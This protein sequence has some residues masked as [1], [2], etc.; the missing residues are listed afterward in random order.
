MK[1]ICLVLVLMAIAAGVY[2]VLRKKKSPIRSEAESSEDNKPGADGEND[3][4]AAIEAAARLDFLAHIRSFAG[5]VGPL[6]QAVSDGST[7]AITLM[8][9]AWEHQVQDYANLSRYFQLIVKAPEA[10]DVLG[11]ADTWISTL[12]KWG[13]AHDN[14]GEIIT[15][16]SQTAKRYL[17]DQSCGFGSKVKIQRP[18]WYITLDGETQVVEQGTGLLQKQE[19]ESLCRRKLETEQ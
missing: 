17:V 7:E 1:W 2:L 4:R 11:C 16:D 8:L 14:P 10:A 19:D 15:L 3:E 13:L 9:Q 6:A 18:A 12:E 5:Y